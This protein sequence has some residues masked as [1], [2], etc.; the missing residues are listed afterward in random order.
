[1]LV[2]ERVHAMNIIH[3]QADVPVRA[4]HEPRDGEVIADALARVAGRLVVSPD[5]RTRTMLLGKGEKTAQAPPFVRFADP[6]HAAS[7]EAATES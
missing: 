5:E 7:R 1:M 2:D 4:Q 6:W 3:G